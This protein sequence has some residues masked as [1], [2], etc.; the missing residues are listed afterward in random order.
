MKVPVK[1]KL[2]RECALTA[3]IKPFKKWTA[4]QKKTVAACVDR[5]MG[6]SGAKKAKKATR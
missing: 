5:K 4:S 6:L 3:G 1:L 2:T